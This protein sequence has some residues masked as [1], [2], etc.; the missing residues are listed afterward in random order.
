M[1]TKEVTVPAYG[2]GIM[3]DARIDMSIQCLACN[4]LHNNMTTC[5][6]FKKGIPTKILTGGFDHTLPFRGD[7]G[8]RFERIT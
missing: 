5:R 1:K 8:I 2:E 6:A 3:G 4:N 7:N